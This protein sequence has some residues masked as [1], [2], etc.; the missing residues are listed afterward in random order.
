MKKTII[1]LWII[2]VGFT[3][4]CT[5]NKTFTLWQLPSQ[6]NTIGNSYVIQ[7]SGGKMI[8]MDGGVKEET[9]Y[10][11]GFLAALGNEVEAWFVTHPHPDHIE[12]LTEILKQPNGLNIKRIYHS[13]FS[14]SYLD[15]EPFYAETAYRFYEQLDASEIATTDI[16]QP[17]EII[18]ID[19]VSLK[20]LTVTNETISTNTYNN[21]SIAMKVW[22]TSKSILFLADLGLEAGDLLLNSE[23]RKNLDCDYLQMAHHGQKGVSKD[24]YRT[25]SF[26]ACLWPTPS[27]VY[28]NDIGNGYNTHDLETVEIRELMKELGIKEHY[29]SCEGLW[30][31]Q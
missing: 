27:W 22:D 19:G 26:R 23:F 29:V 3:Q 20:I 1:F 14:P 5:Q 21:S 4:S 7:T 2:V 25:I 13:R 9:S 8:V 17:G 12:A 10:L 16:R 30:K 31:I 6:V 24:F 18:E 15:T 28:N 11:R